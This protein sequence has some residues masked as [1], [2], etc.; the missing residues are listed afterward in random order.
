MSPQSMQTI[1]SRKCLQC[2][3]I[4]SWMVAAAMLA[5][6][7]L[8]SHAFACACGCGVF[9]VGTSSLMCNGK[10]ATVFLEYD[11]MNQDHN[12]S[13]TSKAPANDNDDKQIR[14]HFYM[15]GL[16]YMFSRQWG[17]MIDVP[18]T[19]RFFKTTDD[20]TGDIVGFTHEAF[21]DIRLQAL[22]AGFSSDMSTGVS[23]GVK[24]PTGGFKDT[25]FDRDTAIGSGSTDLLLGL[26]HIGKI[27]H[28][29]TWVWFGQAQWDKPLAIQGGYRPGAEIDAALGFYYNDLYLGRHTKLAPILQL[30]GSTRIKDSGPAA[31]PPNTG[32]DRLM[33]SPALELDYNSLKLYGDV[34]FPIY[35]HMNGNQLVAPALFKFIISYSL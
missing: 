19:Q 16:Q 30:I 11:F 25:N 33:I 23:L 6:S 1:S 13:G 10:G 15:A 7:S 31:D 35:Q 2:P 14:S 29:N 5:A 26:Y 3:P 32:Y 28:D 34:E 17:V 12:W 4:R 9:D 24:L 8:P 20:A 22:Y 21:G 18:Y 27:V